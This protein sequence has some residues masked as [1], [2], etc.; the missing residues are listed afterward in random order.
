M[1]V[2]ELLQPLDGALPLALAVGAVALPLAVVSRALFLMLVSKALLL[3][4]GTTAP[5]AGSVGIGIVCIA[6][7]AMPTASSDSRIV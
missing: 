7:I 2:P 3:A 6:R 1:P 4:A 5:R